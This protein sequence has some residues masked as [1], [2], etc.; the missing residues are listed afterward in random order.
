MEDCKDAVLP[1]ID[2][3]TDGVDIDV[4]KITAS[5]MKSKEY[6]TAFILDGI[7]NYNVFDSTTDDAGY[8]CTVFSRRKLVKYLRSLDPKYVESFARHFNVDSE[9]VSE[10]V[11]RYKSYNQSRMRRF[12]DRTLKTLSCNPLI[13]GMK[14]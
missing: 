8:P 10:V 7:V 12:I 14:E 11:S 1:P 2:V 9:E 6:M 13:R 4:E 3:S 5:A